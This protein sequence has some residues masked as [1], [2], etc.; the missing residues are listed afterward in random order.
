MKGQNDEHKQK[1]ETLR[2]QIASLNEI[3]E[4]TKEKY[5]KAKHAKKSLKQ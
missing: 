5:Y 2:K 1:E 3:I 4:A